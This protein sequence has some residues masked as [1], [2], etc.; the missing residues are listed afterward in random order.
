M[1]I[2]GINLET[3][4][5]NAMGPQIFDE[6]FCQQTKQTDEKPE[7][8]VEKRLEDILVDQVETMWIN[9]WRH[10]RDLAWRE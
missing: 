1:K 9:A 4:L 3:K 5:Y 2:L 10:A 6:V 7:S 8:R